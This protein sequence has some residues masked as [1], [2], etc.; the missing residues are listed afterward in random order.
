LLLLPL[1][2][3]LP[4]LPLLPVLPPL[5]PVR[6]DSRFAASRLALASANCTL[7][8]GLISAYEMLTVWFDSAFISCPQLIACSIALRFTASIIIQPG[9][10]WCHCLHSVAIGYLQM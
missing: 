8:S 4:L 3:L 10:G 1:P 7:V 9:L 5:P 2:P 6:R